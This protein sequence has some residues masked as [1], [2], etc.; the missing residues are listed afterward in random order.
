MQISHSNFYF[1]S[2]S[3]SI[4]TGITK[5]ILHAT[6]YNIQYQCTN[7]N[8][9]VD[10]LTLKLKVNLNLMQTNSSTTIKAHVLSKAQF[11]IL[12][13]CILSAVGVFTGCSDLWQVEVSVSALEP[14]RV[15]QVYSALRTDSTCLSA[16]YG[17]RCPHEHQ[18]ECAPAP[19]NVMSQSVPAPEST[20]TS[21]R[22]HQRVKVCFS[23]AAHW[24][25]TNKHTAVRHI[26]VLTEL[27]VTVG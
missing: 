11:N 27:G 17:R 23:T 13:M 25:Y 19:V 18:Q 20:G 9:Q 6:H 7:I 5:P 1:F 15:G 4:N 2:Y 16:H 24:L 14:L 22:P 26:A 10:V 12:Y 8:I 3:F 21:E